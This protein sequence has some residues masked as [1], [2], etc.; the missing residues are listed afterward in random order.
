MHSGEFKKGNL[1]GLLRDSSG[2]QFRMLKRGDSGTQS[3]ENLVDMSM[4]SNE[5]GFNSNKPVA[6]KNPSRQMH[7]QISKTNREGS[8]G[9]AANNYRSVGSSQQLFIQTEDGDENEAQF[10]L[11]QKNK[12]LHDKIAINLPRNMQNE[13]KEN[14]SRAANQV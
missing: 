11:H 10:Q 6:H 1:S 3:K 2:S 5:L 7:Q 9:A 12:Q 8:V 4:T 13:F 14:N